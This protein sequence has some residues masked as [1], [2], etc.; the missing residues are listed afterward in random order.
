MATA[1]ATPILVLKRFLTNH[2][3]HRQQPEE[4]SITNSQLVLFYLMVFK[5]AYAA[6]IVLPRRCYDNIVPASCQE[7]SFF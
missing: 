2:S 6:K 3:R 1:D 4:S 7:I 5:I